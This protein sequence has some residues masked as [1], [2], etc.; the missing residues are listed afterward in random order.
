MQNILSLLM[1]VM[2]FAVSGIGG[3]DSQNVPNDSLGYNVELEEV[4]VVASPKEYGELRTQPTSV[5]MVSGR[6]LRAAGI[7][8][9]KGVSSL[10][11]NFFMPDYGSRLTS[12]IYIRGIGS[13]IGTP[14]IGMYV[15]DVPYYDKTA[16]DFS[17]ADNI[18]RVDVL[19]GPQSTL[20]G[21]NTMGGLVRVYTKSPENYLG[22][23]VSYS[24]LTQE[25]RH[26]ISVNHYGWVS[27][28]FQFSVGAFYEDGQGYFTNSTTGEKV[29]WTRSGGGHVRGIFS[30][31]DVLKFD[32]KVN[33]EYS[34]EGAYPYFL[35]K[36][37]TPAEEPLVG[38]ISSNLEGR[39]RRG[40]LNAGLN[41]EYNINDWLTLYSVTAWQN[42]N[43]RMFMDQDFIRDDI[44]S[45]EQRQRLNTVSEELT[46]KKHESRHTWSHTPNRWNWITGASFAYQW[47]NTKAPVNFRKDG[48]DW[49]NSVINTNANANMPPVS[50]G[51]MTMN[52]IFDDRIN[53][54][55]LLLDNDFDTPMLTTALFH[56][57]VFD[58]LF[59]VNDLELTIGLRLDYEKMWMDYCSWYDFIHTYSLNGKLTGMMNRDIQMVKP[60]DYMAHTTLS[61]KLDH[62]YLQLLPRFALKYKLG[63]GNVYATV[64]RGYRSGGYNIQN[65]SELMRSQMTADMMTDVRDV[66]L[67][68]MANYVQ[69]EAVKGR[70]TDIMN[71]MADG[72]AGN[73][74]DACLFRPEY[75]W[76][77]EVGTHFTVMTGL[78]IDA[79][80]FLSD[81][82]DLQLSQMTSSGLGRITVNAGKSRTLGGELSV[83]AAPTPNL[84]LIANYGYTYATLR[85]YFDYQSDGSVVDCKGNYV[86]FMPK[87]TVSVDAAYTFRLPH[88]TR[89]LSLHSVTIGA[90]YAGAG[91]IYW[92]EANDASQAYYSLFGARLV[93]GFNALELQCSLR[94]IT[95]EKYNT[96][97]FTSMNRAYEQHG[98]PFQLGIDLRLHL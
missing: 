54:S 66:T 17:L 69:D 6:Q 96:F 62:D 40:L 24:L 97:Y 55:N 56:Q 88:T 95:A 64:S 75:A 2:P 14:A 68:I 60:A 61:G 29:D 47:L 20:Y 34:D 76:N 28:P 73:V 94:N 18:A 35:T 71:T 42:V 67:P 50:M 84:T 1:A 15:D 65:I 51:P 32:M 48:V 87:H 81:V 7:T 9:L 82:R 3:N 49:L 11:P 78:D 89:M 19:R 72:G 85:N 46:L 12:A 37:T 80:L 26:R 74:S 13:R 70:I 57:S 16:F 53:G 43:D 10:V 27:N 79:S 52:F 5:S 59:G 22:T 44:Y 45:L 63:N 4:S 33:Y 36:A 93:L 92:T 25:G 38:K 30:P 86:P 91:R 21:R 90:N 41:T 77:Y 83:K 98:K 23:D 39:Y 31:S 58:N 8:S